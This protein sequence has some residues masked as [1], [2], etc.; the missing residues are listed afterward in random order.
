[1]DLRYVLRIGVPFLLAAMFRRLMPSP[2][3]IATVITSPYGWRAIGDGIGQFHEAVDLAAPVA[4]P[5]YASHPGVARRGSSSRGGLE[6]FVED[7]TIATGY[8]HLSGYAVP[9]M[10]RV[11]TGELI[12]YTGATGAVTGPHLHLTHRRHG[13]KVDPQQ[14][15]AL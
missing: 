10:S 2:L 9:D 7:G 11:D 13:V 15:F 6:L 5:I 1:M 3:R 4:T 14:Y 12:A 8:A